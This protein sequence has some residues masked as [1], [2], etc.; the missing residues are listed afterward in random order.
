[1][2]LKIHSINPDNKSWARSLPRV[3]WA[4]RLAQERGCG[5]HL[6]ASLKLRGW[7]VTSPMLVSHLCNFL[8]TLCRYP[9][10]LTFISS[11]S[12]TQERIQGPLSRAPVSGKNI[13][14]QFFPIKEKLKREFS[15]SDVFLN[16]S[17]GP[18][19]SL[20]SCR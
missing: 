17:S 10:R 15:K 18:S 6:W 11:L 8:V 20:N 19:I 12:I 5:G 2:P 3:G 9:I 14:H 4:D 16:C 1:M 7:E 13:F